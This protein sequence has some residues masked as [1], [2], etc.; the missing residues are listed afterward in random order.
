[1]NI[2]AVLFD[3]DGTLIDSAPDLAAAVDM[4]RTNRGMPSLPYANYRQVAG[5]GAGGLLRVAFN[6]TPEHADY[7]AYCTEFLDNYEHDVLRQTHVFDGIVA[8]LDTLRS[9]HIPWGIVT[10]KPKRFAEPLVAQ[11]LELHDAAVVI[12]GDTT[13]HPKPHPAPLLEAAKRMQIPANQF[14]Y[15]GDDQRDIQAAHAANMVGMAAVWGYLGEATIDSWGADAIA[16]Q[17]QD[18]WAW[19]KNTTNF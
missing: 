17:P 5:A 19:L 11:M 9:H 14:L 1:M 15:V 8:V 4:M 7:A 16:Q 3:L 6:I 2:Q 18:V 10:N 12:G 13:P